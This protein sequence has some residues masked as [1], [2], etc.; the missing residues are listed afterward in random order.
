MRRGIRLGV[1]VGKARTG[2]A[3]SDSAGIMALPVRTLPA[4]GAD[5]RIT[6]QTARELEALEVI[7]GLPRNM[8]GSEGSAAK[9]ARRW[10]RRLA[11]RIAPTPV[12]LVDERLSTV[13]AHA[14]LSASGLS[15][16][17]HRGLVDQAAAVVI[18]ET[19]LE[20]ER[21]SG[22]KPG[23]LVVLAEKVSTTE[24]PQ[25]GTTEEGPS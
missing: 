8:D 3:K 17:K 13:S 19:A 14:Q 23:E 18:L 22:E 24:P 6:A 16:R 20:M 1:D 5:L 15:T 12:R 2:L 25:T 11:R 21:V 10:A 9:Y 4:N 7:V